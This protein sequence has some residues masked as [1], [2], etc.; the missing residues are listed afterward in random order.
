[1]NALQK[2]SLQKK[3]FLKRVLAVFTTRYTPDH[4]R[5]LPPS[6]CSDLI[7]LCPD[8]IV[9]LDREGKIIIFNHAA[10]RLFGMQASE[11]IHKLT[12]DVLYGS[13]EKARQVKREIYSQ[14]H[15][16]AGRLEGYE[17]DL[18]AKDGEKIPVRLSATLLYENNR[19]LGSVG[20][21]HDI[22]ASKQLESRL[23]ELSIRDGLSGLYNHRHFHSVLHEELNRA[24]RYSRYLSLLCLDLDHFKQFNDKV[25]HLEGDNIIRYVGEQ[26]KQIMRNSDLAFR[27]GGDEFMVLLPETEMSRAQVV[28][29][30]IRQRFNA[31]WPFNPGNNE[32]CPN[33]VTLSVGVAEAIPGEDSQALINRADMA[34]YEAKRAGGDHTV[35]AQS[36]IGQPA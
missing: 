4:T 25:G 20:F 5:S 17:V 24:K 34:M 32:D 15:G 3:S 7:A 33:P 21:F 6:L 9:G 2:H 18:F 35:E 19:E 22:S 10:E 12:I 11:A 27:Y 23:R 16:G 31:N 26:L 14:E 13:M 29:E 30:K 8:A 28:A 36:H 1:M